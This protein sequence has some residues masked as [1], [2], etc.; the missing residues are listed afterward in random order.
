[1]S[2]VSE[3]VKFSDLG[4]GLE[5]LRFLS[6]R[7]QEIFVFSI[8]FRRA[9]GPTHLLFNAQWGFIPEVKRL[10]RDFDHLPL[11]SAEVNNEW[12]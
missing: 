2:Y 9:L 5:G 8:T 7:G 10:E 4:Y 12:S 3:I 11:S 6:R 1:M